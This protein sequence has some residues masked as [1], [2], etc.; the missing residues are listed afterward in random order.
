MTAFE[1]AIFE[2]LEILEYFVD[3]LSSASTIR[4]STSGKTVELLDV[5]PDY[6]YLVGVL[7]E[8]LVKARIRVKGRFLAKAYL[9]M[10]EQNFQC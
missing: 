4:Y 2:L 3:R 6:R 1:L 10:F 9:V 5:L 7:T 8:N